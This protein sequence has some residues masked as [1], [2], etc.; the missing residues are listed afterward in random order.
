MMTDKQKGEQFKSFVETAR[1]LGCDEDEDE[2]EDEERFEKALGRI[3]RHRPKGKPMKMLAKKIT[4][5][6]K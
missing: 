4:K 5:K 6:E 1:K 2:D 3:V